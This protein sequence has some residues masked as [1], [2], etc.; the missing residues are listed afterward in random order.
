MPAASDK[1]G[2]GAYNSLLNYYERTQGPI[3]SN[4][5]VFNRWTQPIIDRFGVSRWEDLPSN[6]EQVLAQDSAVST[7]LPTTE[8]PPLFSGALSTFDNLISSFGGGSSPLTLVGPGRG[9]ISP[10]T[11]NDLQP[12]APPPNNAAIPGTTGNQPS[13]QTDPLSLLSDLLS[14]VKQQKAEPSIVTIS[15]TNIE[16]NSATY[17]VNQNPTDVLTPV[18][19]SQSGFFNDVLASFNSLVSKVT[20]QRTEPNANNGALIAQG[21]T[22]R[23]QSLMQPISALSQPFNEPATVATVSGLNT[24][25]NSASQNNA[26]N[27]LYIGGLLLLGVLLVFGLR[28]K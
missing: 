28:S 8:T 24:G 2:S 22:E 3:P 15:P 20:T 12:T 9:D 27:P 16:T 14:A 4:G 26:I 23:P 18:L 6:Y 25:G 5:D 11:V 1:L 10:A 19:Q 7:R 21:L 17:N 13:Q